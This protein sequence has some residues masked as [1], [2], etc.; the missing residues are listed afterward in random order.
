MGSIPPVTVQ[1]EIDIQSGRVEYLKQSLTIALAGL[2]GIAVL[3]TDKSKL[4]TAWWPWLSAVAAS[5]LLLLTAAMAY[6]AL[7][8]YAN[9][10]K[11][12]GHGGT[13][14]TPDQL[15][16]SLVRH[17][18]RTFILLAVATAAIA[19]YAA[20]QL[21]RGAEADPGSASSALAMARRTMT[22]QELPT[23][24]ISFR[25]EKGLYVAHFRTTGPVAEC[26][27]SGRCSCR[28]RHHLEP[29][30][31]ATAVRPTRP[32]TYRIRINR[33]SGELVEVLSSEAS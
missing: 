8:T 12:I 18:F 28:K 13:K 23:R 32:V 16:L 19:S 2:A 30:C 14:F 22:G 15:R 25:A 7:S 4:P 26:R 17:S 24:L 9:L 27:G 11:Q 3:F 6:M 5:L 20:S 10:L 21:F 29:I 1:G 33:S 31:A